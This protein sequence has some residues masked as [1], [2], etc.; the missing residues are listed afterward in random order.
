MQ[1]RF[2]SKRPMLLCS[3]G[4]YLNF[5]LSNKNRF[6]QN[7]KVEVE[8]I[9]LDAPLQVDQLLELFSSP[10]LIPLQQKKCGSLT[11]PQTL[12]RIITG[13]G[14]RAFGPFLMPLL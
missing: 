5:F 7:N 10:G 1:N 11:R 4:A 6:Y 3:H 13:T 8:E 2:F 14:F 9:M 12:H